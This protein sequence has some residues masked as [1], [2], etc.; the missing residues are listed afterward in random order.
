MNKFFIEIFKSQNRSVDSESTE[1][2]IFNEKNLR[3]LSRKKVFCCHK[4][5]KI[6]IILSYLQFLQEIEKNY[7][8][9]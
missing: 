1:N 6:I 2:I 5:L 8:K 3:F 9:I 7:Q 4:P